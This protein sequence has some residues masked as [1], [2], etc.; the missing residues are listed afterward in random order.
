MAHQHRKRKMS[1]NFLKTFAAARKVPPEVGSLADTIITNLA[2]MG[3][4]EPTFFPMTDDK[5]SWVVLTRGHKFVAKNSDVEAPSFDEFW[6]EHPTEKVKISLAGRVCEENRW[7]RVYSNAGEGE[8][9]YSSF[10]HK[11]HDSPTFIVAMNEF[12]HELCNKRFPYNGAVVNW[13]VASEAK[14]PEHPC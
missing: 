1:H 2:R 11:C 13:Y 5:K 8:Y 6:A 14:R 3:H 12:C 9:R 7:S 4:D 10:S